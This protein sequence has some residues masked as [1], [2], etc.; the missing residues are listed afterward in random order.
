MKHYKLYIGGEWVEASG[1]SF[2]SFNPYTQ[3]AWAT[4]S[5]ATETDVQKA[6]DAAREAFE[7]TW[8]LT[9]GIER[10]RLMLRLAELIEQSATHF[11]K[12]ESTDNGKIIRETKS[13]MVFFGR[14]LRFFAGF[15]DKLWGKNIPLDQRDL[16]N[17]TSREPIGVA[18]VITAWNSPMALL[19]NKLAPALA[20]G[21]CMVVKPSEHASVTTLE[22]TRLVEEAGFPRGVFNVV[23]GRGATGQ[24][25]V[26]AKGIGRVSFTGSPHVGRQIAADAGRNLVPVTME[27]GGKSANI[28]F[29]DAD[30]DKAVL[31][32]IAGIFGATGQTCIAGSRLLVHREVQQEVVHRLVTRA[33]KIK[34]GDPLSI[35]TEMGTVANEAQF[36]RILAHIDA[37]KSEGANLATG[38]RRA[39][40]TRLG[41]G[42]FIEPT[43][44]NDVRN[45]MELAQEEIFGPVLAVI[46]F[47]SDEE[48]VAIA[49][50]SRFGLA[51]GI[52]TRDVNRV[53]RVSRELRVGTIWVNTYRSVAAQAPFGGVKESGFGRERGEEALLE[54]LTTKNVMI[55][56][57][58]DARDPFAV[59]S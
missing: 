30:L 2:E 59:K 8:R 23:T 17:L 28:V 20:A 52:W 29:A 26:N 25:L 24:A 43:I 18:A 38:G 47:S 44:F 22:F 34:L 45:D 27:L 42:L 58:D 51:G 11:G 21:C 7:R 53:L 4:I 19:A 15:A 6:V 5:E 56:F 12:L 31:G 3:K 41:Q 32:A 33:Q 57:S 50:D 55:N 14:Q 54:Y 48:A 35:D 39:Q 1:G 49:N 9:S 46:P 13:Q 37:A 10:A 36:K 40:G 16:A